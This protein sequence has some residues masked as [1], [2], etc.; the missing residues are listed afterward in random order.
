MDEA[1]CKS[2]YYRKTP[3]LRRI[4]FGILFLHKTDFF[5]EFGGRLK[6]GVLEIF[7][8]ENSRKK[9]KKNINKLIPFMNVSFID[10]GRENVLYCRL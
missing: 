6:G 9:E 5:P 1:R 2:M 8:G 4:L 7:I 3:A 10:F